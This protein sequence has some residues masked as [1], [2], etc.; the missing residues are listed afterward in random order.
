MVLMPAEQKPNRAEV[1]VGTGCSAMRWEG[2]ITI[3][4]HTL[5][6]IIEYLDALLLIGGAID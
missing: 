4:L 6:V 2:G 3:G 5:L 1:T